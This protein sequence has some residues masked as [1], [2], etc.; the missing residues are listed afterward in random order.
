V[1]TIWEGGGGVSTLT[2]MVTLL[3]NVKG[4]LPKCPYR[5][6]SEY[7]SEGRMMNLEVNPVTLWRVERDDI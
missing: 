6:K 4:R 2:P 7:S 3:S 5:T 1:A